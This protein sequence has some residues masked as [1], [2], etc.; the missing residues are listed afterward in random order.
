MGKRN[1]T[2]D[3]SVI[4]AYWACLKSI[5]R[6]EIKVLYEELGVFIKKFY[7]GKHEP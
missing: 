4:A 7:Y 5:D 2:Y 3:A 1:P 6:L